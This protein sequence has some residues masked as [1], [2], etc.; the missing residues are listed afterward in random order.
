MEWIFR[1]I[2]ISG[3]IFALMVLLG[4]LFSRLPP[5]FEIKTGG[6]PDNRFGAWV[7]LIQFKVNEYR[8]GHVAEWE[9]GYE[10]QATCNG[11]IE[12]DGETSEG[13]H[14]TFT[15]YAF[16]DAY[17]RTNVIGWVDA[18]PGSIHIRLS[19]GPSEVRDILNEMRLNSNL[20]LHVH[21]WKDD[22]GIKVEHFTLSPN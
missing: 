15:F 8:I 18:K 17:T 7:D 5:K 19:L 21:G 16:R 12:L 9:L 6:H 4:E 22:K 20:S 10:L 1:A 14:V 11:T 2:I 3:A 13:Q